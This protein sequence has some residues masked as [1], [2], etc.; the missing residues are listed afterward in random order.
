MTNTSSR[1]FAHFFRTFSFVFGCTQPPPRPKGESGPQLNLAYVHKFMELKF[2]HLSH[3]INQLTGAAQHFGFSAQDSSTLESQMNA[4][5]NV[6]CSPPVTLNPAQGAQLFSL[7]QHETCPLAAPSAD[8]EAY[9]NLG[10]GGPASA[11]P[12]GSP[13]PTLTPSAPPTGSIQTVTQSVSQAPATSPAAPTNT[14]SSSSSLKAGPIAG[15]AIG[16]AAVVLGFIALLV[17]LL[18]RRRPQIAPFSQATSNPSYATT[19]YPSSPYGAPTSPYSGGAAYP[20]SHTD[21]HTSYLSGRTELWS[22]PPQE[23]DTPYHPGSPEMVMHKPKG[24]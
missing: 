23:M 13:T 2:I 20:P 19:P 5:Y 18:R 16:G 11:I 17:F 9:K 10:P 7:C 12:S 4:R 15:I 21:G 3:F 24:A 1:L 22:P 14:S 6:R 8:C